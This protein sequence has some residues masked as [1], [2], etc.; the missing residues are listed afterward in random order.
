MLPHSRKDC[1]LLDIPVAG[2]RDNLAKT[3]KSTSTTMP[4]AKSR[5]GERVTGILPPIKKA[6]WTYWFYLSTLKILS[7]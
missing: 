7:S 4:R 6:Y 3:V 1:L 2:R 5:L